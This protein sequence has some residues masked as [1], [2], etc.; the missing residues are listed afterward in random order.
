MKPSNCPY[1]AK[2]EPKEYDGVDESKQKSEES[3]GER[4]KFRRQK[5]CCE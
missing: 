2:S 1:N 5:K 4:E 3:I